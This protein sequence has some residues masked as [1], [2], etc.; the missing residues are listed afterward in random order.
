MRIIT[1]F[2]LSDVWISKIGRSE[3]NTEQCSRTVHIMNMNQSLV[4]GWTFKSVQTSHMKPLYRSI[5][6]LNDPFISCI[7]ETIRTTAS[8]NTQLESTHPAVSLSHALSLSLFQNMKQTTIFAFFRMYQ[9]A[10]SRYSISTRRVW[11]HRTKE[12]R[13]SETICEGREYRSD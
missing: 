1:Q 7:F 12:L 9:H 5:P 13:G 4:D 10:R 11:E 8:Q 3:R 6:R 2:V